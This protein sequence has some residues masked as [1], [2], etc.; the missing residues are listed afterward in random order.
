VHGNLNEQFEDRRGF[1]PEHESGRDEPA[2]QC[3][4]TEMVQQGCEMRCIEIVA[5]LERKL[6]HLHE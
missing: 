5:R 4:E 1:F 3:A 2:H 6:S